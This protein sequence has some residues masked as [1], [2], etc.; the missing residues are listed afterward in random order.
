MTSRGLGC[1]FAFLPR[2]PMPEQTPLPIQVSSL[3]WLL[4]E[5]I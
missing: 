3:D 2:V 5:T 1:K 4:A